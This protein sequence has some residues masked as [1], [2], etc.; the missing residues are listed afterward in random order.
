[1]LLLLAM[2]RL[3][4]TLS[5]GVTLWLWCLL[6]AAASLVVEHKLEAPGLS[7]CI[8]QAYLLHSR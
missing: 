8:R 4:L 1:M 5:V 2:H 6:I 7:S 3:S